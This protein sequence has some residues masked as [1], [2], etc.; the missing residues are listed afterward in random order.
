MWINNYSELIEEDLEELRSLIK[1]YRGHPALYRIRMLYFLKVGQ[2]GSRRKLTDILSCSERSLQRWW[3]TY[4]EKG[5]ESLLYY[6]SPSGYDEYVSEE[7]YSALEEEMKAGRIAGLREVK[8]Y[9]SEHWNVIYKDVSAISRLFKRRGVKL[10][11]GRRGHRNADLL[12]QKAFK[13]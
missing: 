4:R 8:N 2:V 1:T 6:G 9:L 5:L 11:T 7:A 13:K 3:S 10:K 12:E